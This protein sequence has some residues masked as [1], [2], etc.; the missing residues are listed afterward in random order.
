MGVPSENLGEGVPK[1]RGYLRFFGGTSKPLGHHAGMTVH[2]KAQIVI[3]QFVIEME[4]FFSPKIIT[5][6][7]NYCKLRRIISDVICNN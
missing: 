5:N 6:Y 7:V 4:D 3:T 1:N 2:Q